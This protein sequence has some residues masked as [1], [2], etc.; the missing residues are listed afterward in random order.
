MHYLL[1]SLTVY[2]KLTFSTSWVSYHDLIYMWNLM[3]KIIYSYISE[4]TWK[5]CRHFGQLFVIKLNRCVACVPGQLLRDECVCP[6]TYRNKNALCRGQYFFL[7]CTCWL[8]SSAQF[9][10]E[11][12]T[13]TIPVLFP[14][15]NWEQKLPIGNAGYLFSLI[16]SD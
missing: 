1:D 4:G 8:G 3:N 6:Q 2:L 14:K 9:Q 5:W 7:D 13:V 10:I 15:T 11:V 12:V 16:S